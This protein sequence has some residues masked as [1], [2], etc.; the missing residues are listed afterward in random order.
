M[1]PAATKSSS[2]GVRTRV[3]RLLVSLA[4]WSRA[5]GF[6]AG[7]IPPRPTE[8]WAE[9][10]HATSRGRVVDRV[11]KAKVP[12]GIPLRAHPTRPRPLHRARESVPKARPNPRRRPAAIPNFPW[13]LIVPAL[14]PGTDAVVGGRGGGGGVRAARRG[15]S[16]TQSGAR[17][18]A[19]PLPSLPFQGGASSSSSF[20]ELR[21]PAPARSRALRRR[22]IY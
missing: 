12:R 17:G 19:P 14:T 22:P 7:L 16:G 11:L 2:E 18:V 6:A 8:L 5:L 10:P 9:R 3:S 4:L 1:L 13:D 20:M 15:S 21:R